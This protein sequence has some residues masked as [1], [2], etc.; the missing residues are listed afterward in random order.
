M[1]DE[2]YREKKIPAFTCRND[3]HLNEKQV[4]L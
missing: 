1:L 4:T 3:I 2:V